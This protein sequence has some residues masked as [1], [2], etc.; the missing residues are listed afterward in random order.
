MNTRRAFLLAGMIGVGSFVLGCPARSERAGLRPVNLTVEVP[1]LIL[2]PECRPDAL[3]RPAYCKSRPIRLTTVSIP[4][5]LESSGETPKVVVS[6][7]NGKSLAFHS[8]DSFASL[9]ALS[10]GRVQRNAV[11]V[12]SIIAYSLDGIRDVTVSSKTQADFLRLQEQDVLESVTMG[13]LYQLVSAPALRKKVR[14]VIWND[15]ESRFLIS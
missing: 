4:S 15:A 8:S 11:M 10:N 14:R 1:Q 6:F 5:E 7:S 13:A 9:R 2:F 12:K 3:E